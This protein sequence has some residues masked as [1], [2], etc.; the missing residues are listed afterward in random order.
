MITFLKANLA[1]LISSFFDYLVTI[2]A[3]QLFGMNVVLANFVG[4]VSGGILN[5][6]LGRKW[7][8]GAMSSSRFVQAKKYFL[9]WVG[10]LLLNALGMYLLTEIGL[11]YVVSKIITSLAVA[12]CY[13]YPLQKRYVFKNSME[14]EV[15]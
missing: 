2:L 12:V 5:F 15:G 11:Y 3:V 10:N 4:N 8:F 6:T 1:S 13:N 7:V 14:Y 9:V